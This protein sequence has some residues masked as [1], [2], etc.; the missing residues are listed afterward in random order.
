MVGSV[1]KN[2]DGNI[3]GFPDTEADISCHAAGPSD[4]CDFCRVH[5]DDEKSAGPRRQRNSTW[6]ELLGH[7]KRHE[8]VFVQI[9]GAGQLKKSR[10][11]Q[12]R[13]NCGRR[14]SRAEPPGNKKEC[15]QPCGRGFR[16][17]Q[18]LAV[19]G[20]EPAE[21]RLLQFRLHGSVRR[22]LS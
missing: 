16:S 5:S 17:R 22:A 18:D 13:D 4:P 2:E 19:C 10:S 3:S 12:K 14:I 21:F 11:Q 9:R 6:L 20:S 7:R 15:P 1:G 8:G